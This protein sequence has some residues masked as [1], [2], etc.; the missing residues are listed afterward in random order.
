MHF[1]RAFAVAATIVF[2]G[3]TA[4]AQE[5][6]QQQYEA[7]MRWAG[8]HQ[9]II[10][11]LV[12]PLQTMPTPFDEGASR[13]EQRRWADEA[14]AWA[15]QFDEVIATVRG[16]LRQLG[17]VPEAGPMSD[18]YRRQEQALPEFIGSMERFLAH[19]RT[20]I[21]AVE[22]NDP[23]ALDVA[24]LASIDAQLLIQTQFRNLNSLQAESVSDGP[25][26]YLLRSFAN[27]YDAL[28]AVIE[29]R[30]ATALGENV[31]R[32][33]AAAVRA[34]ALAMRENARTGRLRVQTELDALPAT[35][36]ADQS[37]FLR[38][39]RLAFATFEGSFAREE[40][41]ATVLDQVAAS[42]ERGFDDHDLEPHLDL[43]GR[44]DYERL[45]D[46]QRRTSLIQN[47]QPPT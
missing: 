46:I 26:R 33:S 23:N 14:G 32:V 9:V 7:L 4:H 43:L 29:A 34:A 17:P 20:G 5:P 3:A 19:Y 27:S 37:D 24:Y 36:A 41:M 28:I 39:V 8:G 10:Q 35:V 15:N 6:T 21:N 18:I 1:F 12:S 40:R 45:S 30:R 2:V 47:I 22:R 25:Q 16:Q 13:R 38:R 11:S 42:L 31:D 44:M